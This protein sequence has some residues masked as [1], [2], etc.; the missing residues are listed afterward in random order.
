LSGIGRFTS[1]TT[2][3]LRDAGIH[4]L[5]TC[6]HSHHGLAPLARRQ[7]PFFWQTPA[8][9]EIFVWN[10]EHYNLGNALGLAP[11][12][13]LTYGFEGELHPSMRL[14]DTHALAATRLPRDLRQLE[15]DGYPQDSPSRHASPFHS[16]RH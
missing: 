5:L 12:A 6:V 10:G 7:F 2:A 8:G 3:I 15:L 14:E 13:A 4:N 1:S 11:G 16:G 9:Q